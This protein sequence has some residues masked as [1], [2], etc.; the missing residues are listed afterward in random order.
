MN[1]ILKSTLSITAAAVTLSVALAQGNVSAW[2]DNTPGNQGRVSYSKA[3]IEAGALG[4]EVLLNA[5]SYND[6]IGGDEKNFVAARE[7]TANFNAQSDTKTWEANEITVE[8]GKTYVVRM[9]VHNDNPNGEN[10]K[11]TGVHSLFSIQQG[12]AESIKINGIIDIDKNNN[13]KTS[14]YW[15]DVVFKSNNGKKFELQYVTGSGLVENNRTNSKVSDDVA[16]TQKGV[17]IGY[18]G[19]LNGELP[20]CFEYATYVTIKVKA[21]FEKE[22]T[23]D[24]FTVEKKVR[25]LGG[26]D[27]GQYVEGLKVGDKVEY[28]IHYHNSSNV[29]STNVMVQ[30]VLP[31]NLRYVPGTARLFN[32]HY[33][34]KTGTTLE[35]EVVGAGANIGGYL[36]NGD[37][38][39]RFTAEVV[40]TDLACGT[41]KLINWGKVSVGEAVA[42]DSAD[43]Y[44]NKTCATPETP[45]TGETKTIPATGPE[46]VIGAVIGA[47]ALTTAGGFYLRSRK[48]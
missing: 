1:K 19:S 23:P 33:D 13:V 2:G 31:S 21:V 40:D 15:D 34:A 3:Q 44:V 8:D 41:T 24:N 14:S 43:V 32:T 22:E 27:W 39:V 35:D 47:G 11:A 26:K 18:D 42:K 9:Y 17:Q 16:N 6:A 25:V 12:M 48:K 4:D 36:A 29:A 28:Q 38:Y 45:K 37:G 30:D 20:G 46:G 7:D 5:M 10:A